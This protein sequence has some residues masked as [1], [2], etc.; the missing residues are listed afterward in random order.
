MRI[1]T[2]LV[3]ALFIGGL[4]ILPQTPVAPS[5]VWAQEEEA[6]G[7][8]GNGGGDLTPPESP[9][10]SPPKPRSSPS[11]QRAQDGVPGAEGR[12][13]VTVMPDDL[14]AIFKW[15]RPDSHSAETTPEY[16]VG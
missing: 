1:F 5:T 6:G 3:V 11:L 16:L 14:I 8:Q 9:S 15:E 13:Q 12:I 4:A 7:G 10:P 2:L